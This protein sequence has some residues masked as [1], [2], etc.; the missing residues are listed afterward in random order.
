MYALGTQRK[1]QDVAR[2]EFKSPALVAAALRRHSEESYR[3][4]YAKYLSMFED[5]V[6]I[7]ALN[8]LYNL[9]KPIISSMTS[10]FFKINGIF[11]HF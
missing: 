9:T 3:V 8:V 11:F 10:Y 1:L 5:K 4:I 2:A 7:E 6:R